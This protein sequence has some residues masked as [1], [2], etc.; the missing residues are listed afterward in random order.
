M[1][2]KHQAWRVSA[3]VVMQDQG[4]ARPK[5]YCLKPSFLALTRRGARNLN[6]TGTEE[7]YRSYLLTTPVLSSNLSAHRTMRQRNER[8]PKPLEMCKRKAKRR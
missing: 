7:A 8:E 1:L 2:G 5:L 6:E 3:Q 4:V